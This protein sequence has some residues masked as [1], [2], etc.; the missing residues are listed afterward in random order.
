MSARAKLT[1][2][3]CR[4]CKLFFPAAEAM[5]GGCHDKLII[6]A[7]DETQDAAEE[8][9]DPVAVRVRSWAQR[10]WTLGT[11]TNERRDFLNEVADDMEA[12]GG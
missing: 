2:T 9:F 11:I 8:T 3:A 5:C 4:E 10:K 6:E 12:D 1:E 7:I